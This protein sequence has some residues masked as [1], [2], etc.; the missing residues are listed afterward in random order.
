MK[1]APELKDML[2]RLLE[3]NKPEIVLRGEVDGDMEDYVFWALSVLRSRN[4]PD[5]IITIDSGGGS[6]DRGHDIY[7]LIKNYEGK[8]EGKAFSRVHS[9]A[10]FILQACTVRKMALHAKMII[11]NP[12]RQSVS[13]D[14]LSS[15]KKLQKLRAD[16]RSYQQKLVGAYVHRSRRTE[17][18]I[19]AQLAK[20]EPL[21]AAE[22]LRMGLIDEI[23]GE[24]KNE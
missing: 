16:L 21:T 17:K 5:L 12:S 1:I 11:H 22:A 20:D 15:S 8:T 7:D 14:E 24:Q 4:S 18:E 10:S 19:I 3:V 23:F 2:K 9:A 13:L 6:S